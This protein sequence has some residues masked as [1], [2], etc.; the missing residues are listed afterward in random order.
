MRGKIATGLLLTPQ[1]H[2]FAGT[3]SQALGGERIRWYVPVGIQIYLKPS[4]IQRARQ[5]RR[6]IEVPRIG[7]ALDISREP[8]EIIG[9][10]LSDLNTEW[11]TIVDP[12]LKVG[13]WDREAGTIIGRSLT[14]ELQSFLS[15]NREG[16]L[17]LRI[18]RTHPEMRGGKER[19]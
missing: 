2:V 1:E 4:E 18:E 8:H 6:Y 13:V 7:A 19:R 5:Q 17:R 16:D 9:F 15:T 12:Y 14:V 3:I 10:A 11:E